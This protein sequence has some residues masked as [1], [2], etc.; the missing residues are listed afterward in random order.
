MDEKE[1]GGD[2]RSKSGE[3]CQAVDTSLREGR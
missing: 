3:G 2:L 1:G